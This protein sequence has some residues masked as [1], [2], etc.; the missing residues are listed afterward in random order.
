MPPSASEK[1]R[2]DFLAAFELD[3]PSD[4]ATLD[5]CCHLLEEIATLEERLSADG[6][7]VTGSAGQP[8]SHPALAALRNHRT[9]F[10]RLLIRLKEDPAT[11]ET[12][13]QQKARAARTR[14]QK[15]GTPREG[16]R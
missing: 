11:K 5:A 14:W 1:F 12:P 9:T 4:E 15:N 13:T 6:P 3:D 7:I 8:I 2:A 10:E 16:K